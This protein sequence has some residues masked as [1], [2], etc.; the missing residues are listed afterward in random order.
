MIYLPNKIFYYFAAG[1]AVLNTI[2][3][4]CSNIVR[5]S[6]SGLDY[7]AGNVQSCVNAIKKV[8]QDADVFEAM[9]NNSRQQAVSTYDRNILY[10][11]FVNLIEK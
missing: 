8:A 10:S 3:G 5:D 9:K 11:K 2:G 7:E 4:Q 6:K 1:L